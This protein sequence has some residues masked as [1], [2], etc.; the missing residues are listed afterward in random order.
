MGSAAVYNHRSIASHSAVGSGGDGGNVD[1]ILRRLGNVETSVT[2][3]RKEISEVRKEV[4]A[5]AATLPHLATAVSVAEV[6]TEIAEVQATI[7]KWFITTALALVTST[8]TI[9]KFFH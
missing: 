4:G 5:I 2:E 7:I 1:D 9:A 8:F 6:R 3:V